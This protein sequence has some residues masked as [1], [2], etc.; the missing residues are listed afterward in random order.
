DMAINANVTAS[1]VQLDPD[2]SA[3]VIDL[4]TDTPGRLGLTQTELNF[5]TTPVLQVGI[6]FNTGGIQVTAPVSRPAGNTLSLL[7][8]GSI[9]EAAAGTI[10]VANLLARGLG[11]GG[12]N[13][14]NA[15]Q[16]TTLAGASPS[17]QPFIVNSI[18]SFTVG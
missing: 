9:T 11:V 17:G 16:I 3:R 18:T 4:G 2:T 6:G 14:P 13:L 10:T 5:I 12:V 8:G 7:T 1:S 15:N